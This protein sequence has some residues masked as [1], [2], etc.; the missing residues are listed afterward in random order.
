M[1]ITTIGW[2]GAYPGVNEATSGYLL[3]AEETGI[4]ID[5]G[6]GVLAQ[7]QNH[8]ELQQLDGVI[9][10]HYHWDHVA[11][12]GCLQYA[13]R[14]QMDLGRRKQP[15]KIYAHAEDDNFAGLNYLHYTS[16]H[17]VAPGMDLRMRPFKFT[18]CRNIHPAPC[19]SMRIEK[20]HQSIVYIS[21]TGYSDELV[22]FAH[23]ADLLLCEASLYDEYRGKIPGHMTAGEAGHL[24]QSAGVR[25]LV[26]T[27]LPH[28]G[29][30]SLLVEQ[31]RRKYNGTVEL[32]ETGKNWRL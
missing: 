3:T 11:D 13:I 30:H 19:F 25:H 18:F 28:F 24:A 27:H 7:L 26:L 12:L 14:I 10:S 2:W 6:S 4:L 16:G 29:R 8:I 17:A 15:L 9:L 23:R 21:D 20:N 1:K 32:A 22:H 5:C 31:A